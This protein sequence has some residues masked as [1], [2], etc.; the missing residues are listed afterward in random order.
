MRILVVGANGMLGHEAVRALHDV[1][2]VIGLCRPGSVMPADLARHTAMRDYDIADFDT[3]LPWLDEARPNVILNCSGV[4]KQRKD[5]AGSIFV[6]VNSLFPHKLAEHCQTRG[7]R[8]IH[9]ST[10]CVFSGERGPYRIEDVADARDLYG[11]SKLLG[12]VGGKGCLTLRTSIIGHELANKTGLLEWFLSQTGSV[13]G[14][15]RALYTG[16][17]TVEIIRFVARLLT[18]FHHLDGIWQLAADEISKYELL[19]IVKD[20]YG[21]PDIEI[22]PDDSFHCDRR[23]DGGPLDALCGYRA[24]TWRQMIEDMHNVHRS[25]AIQTSG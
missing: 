9:F 18:K 14:Y 6:A 16:L 5:V 25:S 24:P 22:R 8:L 23:L 10:D 17:T 4:I 3:V 20:T 2:T 13:N 12:E 19:G 1:G 21:R 15:T 11:R 7:I